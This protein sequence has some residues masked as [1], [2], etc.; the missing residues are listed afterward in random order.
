[1]QHRYSELHNAASIGDPAGVEAVL[2]RDAS[3]LNTV[4]GMGCIVLNC[5]PRRSTWTW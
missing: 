2:A 3:D 5:A 4:D 1:M